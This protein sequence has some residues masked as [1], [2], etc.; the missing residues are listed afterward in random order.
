MITLATVSYLNARPLV[1]GLEHEPDVQVMRRVPSALLETLESGSAQ[2]AL[3]PVIDYQRSAR[4]L[5]IVPVGAI[6]CDGP[7]LTVRLF[8]RHPADRLDEIAVD[9]DSHTSVA[10]LS[11]VLQHRFGRRP[12]LHRLEPGNPDP[13]PAAVLLIGD[14]VIT[15]PP[16]RNLYPHEIDLGEAWR[17]L[18]GTPFVFATWMTP[19]GAALGGLPRRL[20][21][22]R[23]DNSGRLADIAA[24]HARADGWR[25]ELAARYL[26]RN[27]RYE[28]GASEIAA[29]EEFWRQCRELGL[30]DELRPM[31]L[32]RGS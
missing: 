3:C 26:S 19:A 24:R 25:E 28:I 16:D 11:I 32:Y 20:E 27:L 13:H 30:I 14:K 6:G 18:T 1:D 15:D 7:A 22:I 10:L 8:S 31:R 23:R 29:I 9:G 12:A 2:I 4:E 21:R 17:E 5:E